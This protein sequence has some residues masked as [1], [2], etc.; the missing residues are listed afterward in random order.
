MSFF[1]H[2]VHDVAGT[3]SGELMGECNFM[4]FSESCLE[5]CRVFIHR[6]LDAC[7]KRLVLLRILLLTFFAHLMFFHLSVFVFVPFFAHAVHAVA[8]TS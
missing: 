5:E 1:A 6:K 8:S 4:V 3:S 7:D 2:A